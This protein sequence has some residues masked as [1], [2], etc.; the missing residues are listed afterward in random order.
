MRQ[1]I[2]LVL[3]L[4]VTV[5]LGQVP[6]MKLPVSVNRPKSDA[7]IPILS[8]DGSYMLY[9]TNA[10][11]FGETLLAESEKKGKN[12]NLPE[13]VEDI[14]YIP[15]LIRSFSFFITYDNR[16]IY[17]ST[18]KSPTIG[19]F[20]IYAANF[21]KGAFYNPHNIGKPVNTNGYDG[22]PSLTRDG[23]YL[24]FMRCEKM[25][26]DSEENC[27]V[28]VSKRKANGNWNE[29]ELLPEPINVGD[30]RYP[31]ILP[32]NES[33]IFASLRPGGKGGLDLYFSKREKNGW[34][35]PIPL[36]F[37]NT[38][39]DER[40][41]SVP[42][43]GDIIYYSTEDVDGTQSLFMAKLP[44]DLKPKDLFMVKGH[45]FDS[46]NS[47]VEAL[48]QAID[49]VTGEVVEY[50]NSNENDGSF[51]L[52]INEGRSYDFSIVPKDYS[53]TFYSDIFRLETMESSKREFMEIQCRKLGPNI[54][55]PLRNLSFKPYTSEIAEESEIEIKRLILLMQRNPEL[56]FEIGGFINEYKEDTIMTNPDLTEVRYDTIIVTE[57][58]ER[59]D[60]VIT[61]ESLDKIDS[62]LTRVNDQKMDTI[63]RDEVKTDSLKKEVL[64]Y[65]PIMI[66][67]TI[68]V[69]V[70]N[71]FYHNDRS[72]A[73][74]ESLRLYLI[75][76]GAPALRIIANGY[77]DEKW[78]ELSEHR[79]N[80]KIA[81]R[82]I[83]D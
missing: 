60:T 28:Y 43:P 3:T 22:A 32:D 5:S 63:S 72:Q 66:K 46:Q 10:T 70:I 38:P 41:I 48:I 80:V 13:Y 83:G 69:E 51:E 26:L 17:Y 47:P 49:I 9:Y 56:S 54:S 58:I 61:K 36:G 33:L 14:A 75:D 42:F 76:K 50:T 82:V 77:K 11:N 7:T 18:R 16:E 71:K 79:Q 24:Y 15:N 81:V 40:R 57:V 4:V 23:N 74:A 2:V 45:V 25:T 27:R 53:H 65:K 73:M 37:L 67:D 6:K 44:E 12:W 68:E 59:P 62:V 52:Y 8:G 31:Q 19:G 78:E 21:N 20:D 1:L 35:E 64:S 29:P 39:G 34:S 55:F 30:T